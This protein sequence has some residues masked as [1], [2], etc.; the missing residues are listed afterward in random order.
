V[1]IIEGKMRGEG[2]LGG[3]IHFSYNDSSAEDRTWFYIADIPGEDQ[4]SSQ[5]VFEVEWD[6]SQITDGNYDLRVVAEYEGGAAIFELVSG[7][8]I[9]N[10]TPIETRQPGSPTEISGED[11]LLPPS[12][13]PEPER[14]PTPLPSNPV[15]VRGSDIQQVLI[16]TGIAVAGIFFIG[17]I[18][19]AVT[20]RTR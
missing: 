11:P 20:S 2:F 3:T 8:R 5:T 1:E 12:S 6:T 19:W 15:E 14:T 4:G 7:L 9:R 18:Y 16:I 17:I 10:H 13:T